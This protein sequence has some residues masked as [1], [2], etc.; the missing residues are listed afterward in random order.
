MHAQASICYRQTAI[1]T[2]HINVTNQC[3]SAVGR[4]WIHGGYSTKQDEK[5]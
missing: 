5:P 1:I 3:G 4:E 2:A